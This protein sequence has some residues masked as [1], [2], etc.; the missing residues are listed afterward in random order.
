MGAKK[1]RATRLTGTLAGQ[2]VAGLVAL[3][4]VGIGV[5]GCQCLP[6][7]A[8]TAP[9]A[10]CCSTSGPSTGTT[11]RASMSSNGCGTAAGET[12][13]GESLTKVDSAPATRAVVH[14]TAP[15]DEI[16]R[17]A[18]FAEAAPLVRSSRPPILRI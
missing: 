4:L 17:L 8:T 11:V 14:V 15:H 5:E 1:R 9:C 16:D 18:P 10:C 12:T 3:A 7:A 6:K 2:A 13:F